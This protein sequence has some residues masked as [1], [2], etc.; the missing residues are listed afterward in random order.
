MSSKLM[1]DYRREY[2]GVKVIIKSMVQKGK[3]REDLLNDLYTLFY[4]SQENN[5]SIEKIYDGERSDFI[6]GIVEDMPL[7]KNYWIN[8]I[9]SIIFLSLSVI[10]TVFF[11][12]ALI[13]NIQS[14]RIENYI[15]GATSTTDIIVK[16]HGLYISAIGMIVFLIVTIVGIIQVKRKSL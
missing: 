13:L 2:N 5:V 8:K 11:C 14:M 9:L 10:V 3:D 12:Y 15:G 4:T 16:S 7:K 1:K 6:K